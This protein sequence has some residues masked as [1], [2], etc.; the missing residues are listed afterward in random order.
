MSKLSSLLIFLFGALAFALPSGYSW[1]PAALLLLSVG[2]YAR[3]IRSLTL[4][5]ADLLIAASFLS[6]LAAAVLTTLVHGSDIRVL[7]KPSRFLAALLILPFL[8]RYPPRPIALWL[9]VAIGALIA[10]GW[11][12]KQTLLDEMARARGNTQD[13]QFGN[14]SMLFGLLS[15]CGQLWLLEQKNR[16][17][18]LHGVLVLGLI[19]GILGSLLSGSRGG[20][21]ALP[22]GLSVLA[23]FSRQSLSRR[24]LAI[25][26]SFTVVISL[27][28]VTVAGDMVEKR[29]T[30]AISQFG[31]Y[32]ER[33]N[34]SSSVGVRLEL[35]KAALLLWSEKPVYGWGEDGIETGKRMLVEEGLVDRSVIRLSHAHNDYLNLLQKQGSIGF[36]SLLLLYGLPII[37][38]TKGIRA[39]RNRSVPLAGLITCISYIS[40]SF[41]QSFLEHNSGVMVY[42][43]LIATIWA[44]QKMAPTTQTPTVTGKPA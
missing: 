16:N 20:W 25:A 13:I 32:F 4:E 31:D 7:D 8:T 9:G 43:I 22:V 40:F 27:T 14:L 10:G 23:L 2:Y 18:V 36:V 42:S 21:L 35:W 28:A 24:G 26:A 33:G 44:I 41:T 5:K 15:L 29:T 30:Q 38:F 6:F 11:A 19:G 12:V 17:L 37:M 39:N 34:S 3:S 1:G